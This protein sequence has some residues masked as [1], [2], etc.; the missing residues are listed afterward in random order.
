MYDPLL[1]AAAREWRYKPAV[2]GGVPV[3]FKKII[4]VSVDRK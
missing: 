1:I 3:K 4:Q 2:A